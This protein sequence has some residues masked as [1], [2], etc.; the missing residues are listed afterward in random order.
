M[1]PEFNR[2]LEVAEKM[3]SLYYNNVNSDDF[4][5]EYLMGTI[6]SKVVSEAANILNNSVCETWED[7]KLAL[8]NLY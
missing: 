4:Q 7:M 8:K 1:L 6:R 5:N 3:I 2:F